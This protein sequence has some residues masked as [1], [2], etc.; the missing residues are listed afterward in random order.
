MPLTGDSA[1]LRR[2]FA[3]SWD[4]SG[5]FNPL[6]SANSTAFIDVRVRET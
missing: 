1:S 3:S 5:G 4:L 2:L 6:S